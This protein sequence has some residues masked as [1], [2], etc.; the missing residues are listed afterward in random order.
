MLENRI[1]RWIAL[2]GDCIVFAIRKEVR[3]DRLMCWSASYAGWEEMTKAY[4]SSSMRLSLSL[5][6]GVSSWR[7]GFCS[8]WLLQKLGCQ[9]CFPSTSLQCSSPTQP[10]PTSQTQQARISKSR[11]PLHR[12]TGRWSPKL[13]KVLTSPRRQREA[14][15]AMK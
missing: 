2:C 7:E 12:K 3:I 11:D 13:D 10:F 14:S 6:E 4:S 5:Y 9:L 8:D 15:E 1:L